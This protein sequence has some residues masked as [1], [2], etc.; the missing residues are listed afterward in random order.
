MQFFTQDDNY[1][2]MHLTDDPKIIDTIDS[3][4][5]P[6]ELSGDDVENTINDMKSRNRIKLSRHLHVTQNYIPK[7]KKYNPTANDN[8]ASLIGPFFASYLQE[9]VERQHATYDELLATVRKLLK[10]KIS[11]KTTKK[12]IIVNE[13]GKY[14]LTCIDIHKDKATWRKDDYKMVLRYFEFSVKDYDDNSIFADQMVDV[15]NTVNTVTPTQMNV[16]PI[17]TQ[18]ETFVDSEIPDVPDREY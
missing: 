3:L 17:E 5:I 4:N 11:G 12:H 8:Y 2:M 10:V 6:W 14:C 1:E 16:T 18:D 9:Y 15:V 13:S 7:R